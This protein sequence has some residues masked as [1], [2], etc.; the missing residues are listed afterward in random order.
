MN[1]FAL[2]YDP[3]IAAQMLNDWHVKKM[4]IEGAQVLSTALFLAKV[5]GIAYD[6]KY[7]TKSPELWA[8]PARA[9]VIRA[10][11]PT[12]E[13]HGA[14]RWCMS[15]VNYMWLLRH[16]LAI[17]DEFKFRFG[18]YPVTGQ[19]LSQ[20]PVYEAFGPIKFHM[21]MD[22]ASKCDNPVVAYQQYYR[23]QK[24]HLNVWTK[25]QP[26]EWING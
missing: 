16:S 1:V 9:S 8:S 25:R 19:L 15:Q 7:W 11:A 20:F 12:H 2:D 22:E 3:V 18:T 5:K 6:G 10:Y 17:C 14:N 26:P 13:G 24:S 23:T 21:F 4:Y